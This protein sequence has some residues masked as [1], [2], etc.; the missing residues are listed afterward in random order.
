[1]AKRIL[2]IDDEIY[3]TRLVKMNLESE[4]GF[5]VEIAVKGSDGVRLAEKFKPDIILLDLLMPEMNG[6]QVLEELK[7]NT[8]ISR[9]PVIMLSAKSDEATRSEVLGK[10]ARLF[11]PKPIDSAELSKE[12]VKVLKKA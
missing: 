5:K 8:K 12:I 4:G 11:L 7:N 9:I 1:M 2:I 6:F 3:F 10:G